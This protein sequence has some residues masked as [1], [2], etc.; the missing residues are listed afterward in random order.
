MFT[1]ETKQINNS[2][3]TDVNNSPNG[4]KS[5]N[6]QLEVDGLIHHSDKPEFS[7]EPLRD[8]TLNVE[9]GR[10]LGICGSVGSGKS[11]LLAAITG[12][13]SLS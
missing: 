3:K 2:S 1:A 7:L 13:V 11:S 8:L 12:D 6:G 9:Q 10:L 4:L 5:N